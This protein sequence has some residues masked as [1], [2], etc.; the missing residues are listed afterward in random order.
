MA[1]IAGALELAWMGAEA[2]EGLTKRK[3]LMSD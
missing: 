2:M 3:N 1:F